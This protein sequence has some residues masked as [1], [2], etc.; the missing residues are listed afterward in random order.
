MEA[1]HRVAFERLGY[2]TSL[3]EYQTVHFSLMAISQL[4][5][6]LQGYILVNEMAEESAETDKN[7][8]GVQI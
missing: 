4:K 8:E 1:E 6:K 7:L 2:G 5:A 3:E